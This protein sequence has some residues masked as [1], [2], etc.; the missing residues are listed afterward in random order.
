MALALQVVLL[1]D[2]AVALEKM[3]RICFAAAIQ[4]VDFYHALEHAGK[5]LE[6]LLGSKNH[7]Q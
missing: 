4:I 1:I 6:A 7:P 3:G 2:G 5:V